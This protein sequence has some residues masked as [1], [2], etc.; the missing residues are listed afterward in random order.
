MSDRTSSPTDRARPGSASLSLSPSHRELVAKIRL[1]TTD[2]DLMLPEGG[3]SD[4]YD[5][6]DE[7]GETKFEP[8]GKCHENREKGIVKRC[9][10][11]EVRAVGFIPQPCPFGSKDCD[12]EFRAVGHYFVKHRDDG[13]CDI[14]LV[15]RKGPNWKA[16]RRQR[17]GYDIHR[18]L[19]NGISTSLAV[20]M[21]H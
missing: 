19:L 18:S 21:A 20:G 1:L 5:A 4:G 2:T 14:D 6:D 9:K 7:V 3:R 17:F 11:C 15:K 10:E 12:R 16:L 8:C 13:R